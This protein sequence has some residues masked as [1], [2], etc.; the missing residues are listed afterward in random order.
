M[1]PSDT[2][3][4][5][6]PDIALLLTCLSFYYAGISITQ[7]RQ[8][9]GHLLHSEDKETEY[10][11]WAQST[12]SLRHSLRDCHSINMDDEG[13]LKDIWQS[14]SHSTVVIDY[15]LNHFAFP[16]HAQQFEFKLQASGWDI[17]LTRPTPTQLH[18]TGAHDSPIEA[19][20]IPHCTLSTGFSGTSDSKAIQPMNI[21]QNDLKALMRTNAEVLTYLLEPRNQE[22]VVA[23]DQRGIKLSEAALL[24]LINDKN[25]RILIDA[26][27][28]ILEHDNL[29]LVKA[30]LQRDYR[31]PAAVLFINDKA[32]VYHRQGHLTPLSGSPYA[33]DL[34]EC[35]VY[36]DEAHTRGTDLKLPTTARAALTIGL[37]QSKDVTVQA[38]M[39]LRKL[40]TTQSVVFFAPPEVDRSL[41]EYRDKGSS[42]LTSSDVVDWLL[43]QSCKGLEQLQPLFLSQGIDYCLRQ[44]ARADNP[45][46]MSNPVHSDNLFRV[47]KQKE[48]HSLRDQYMPKDKSKESFTD[49]QFTVPE[50][51]SHIAELKRIQAGLVGADINTYELLATQE[52]EQE[53]EISH[54]VETVRE[55]QRPRPRKAVVHLP[56]SGTVCQFSVDGVL[57]PSDSYQPAFNFMNTT[58]VGSQFGVYTGKT[59]SRLFVTRDFALTVETPAKQGP[60][61]SYLKPV[62]WVLYSRV[63]NTALILSAHEAELLIP[64]LRTQVKGHMVHLIL[65]SAPVTRKML[66]FDDLNYFAIPALPFDWRAPPDIRRDLRIFAGATFF[67]FQDYEY[68]CKFL[69]VQTTFGGTA[70]TNDRTAKGS[71]TEKPLRFLQQWL[72]VRRHGHEFSQSPMGYLVEG[73]EITADLPFFA[74]EQTGDTEMMDVDDE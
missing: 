69:G 66:A 12:T 54:E 50:I 24:R 73:K 44:Q 43:E 21:K 22:Y 62:Q 68:L 30:W 13:Q 47:L 74:D 7:F 18:S 61:D 34:S 49:V 8:S 65:Y 45:H 64:Y 3:E 29:D 58:H 9:L 20:D 32:S 37:G 52:V 15:Y 31:R 48:N 42:K 38:A 19:K 33:D 53:R 60:D 71:L 1:L 27:A 56:L 41:R 6:H 55:V 10:D 46:F 28:Q 40:G 11:R 70:Q 35:L 63:D 17:P 36:L 67:K 4:W 16:I 2:A 59:H 25:I 23:A 57:R 39:R 14:L 26:G 51:S 72:A 5:G